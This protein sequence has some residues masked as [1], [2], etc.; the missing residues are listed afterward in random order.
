MDYGFSQFITDVEAGRQ[1]RTVSVTIAEFL[2]DIDGR[3]FSREALVRSLNGDAMPKLDDL[4]PLRFV[5]NAAASKDIRGSQLVGI[6]AS[7][8]AALPQFP[9][10]ML[11]LYGSLND[12]RA[13]TIRLRRFQPF[14]DVE[15]PETIPQF[16]SIFRTICERVPLL[17]E[18]LPVRVRFL[19][20]YTMQR[21][22]D[23]RP[24]QIARISCSSYTAIHQLMNQ[25]H[26]AGRVTHNNRFK[27][28][29]ARNYFRDVLIETG[30]TLGAWLEVRNWR[31]YNYEN[32]ASSYNDGVV[33]IDVDWTDV[34]VLEDAELFH[35][36]TLVMAWDIETYDANS[37]EAPQWQNRSSELSLA[38]CNFYWHW[39]TNMLFSV[40][41]SLRDVSA[42]EFEA[43][44]NTGAQRNPTVIVNCGSEQGLLRG[45][46]MLFRRFQPSFVMGFADTIYDWPWMFGRATQLPPV[47]VPG[48][49][50]VPF[51][52]Y[53]HS[54]LCYSECG[55]ILDGYGSDE[56]DIVERL[57]KHY[58]EPEEV[59][60]NAE[61]MIKS[62]QITTDGYVIIDMMIRNMK[63]APNAEVKHS[64][65]LAYF[66]ET[67]LG[68]K[69][70]I[71][72]DAESP[73]PGIRERRDHYAE[74]RRIIMEYNAGAPVGVPRSADGA[75]LGA[76]GQP[77]V[78]NSR[79][80]DYVYY[81]I[82]DAEACQKMAHK[83][84]LI[85]DNRAL[86]LE[87]RLSMNDVEWRAGGMKV[88]N[89]LIWN[90]R[91]RFA[92]AHGGTTMLYTHH[93]VAPELV[94]K[95]KGAYVAPPLYGLELYSPVFGLDVASL[96]PSIM[97]LYNL[98][99]SQ[100]IIFLHMVAGKLKP[101]YERMWRAVLE[102]GLEN[103]FEIR[104]TYAD[105][106]YVFFVPKHRGDRSKYG[107]LPLMIQ[108]IF[109][110]RI[111]KKEGAKKVKAFKL[112]VAEA[113][114]HSE[115][116]RERGE[117]IT[118]FEFVAKWRNECKKIKAESVRNRIIAWLDTWE[119]A[120]DLPAAAAY[121]L[122]YVAFV[123]KMET[124]NEKAMKLLM[125]TTYG[126]MGFDKHALFNLY[127]SSAV[128]AMGQHVIKTA[129]A[130]A[131]AYGFDLVYGDTDSMYLRR[132]LAFWGAQIDRLRE[133]E[134][135][136]RTEMDPDDP[137]AESKALVLL[138]EARREYYV[139][140]IPAA[141][142]DAKDVCAKV[143]KSFEV[144][145]DGL[146]TI[147]FA[148]EEVMVPGM[149]FQKKVYVGGVHED[150]AV[151]DPR[152]P[153]VH[154]L[155][156]FKDRVMLRGLDMVKQGFSKNTIDST[157]RMLDKLMDPLSDSNLLYVT[158]ARVVEAE[159]EHVLRNVDWTD[160][161]Q[162]V[163][164][165]T[166]KKHKK[167]IPVQE[168]V[169]RLVARGDPRTPADGEKFR[170]VVI[171]LDTASHNIY[172][173][174]VAL[175]AS[176][177]WELLEVARERG[178]PINQR[179]YLEN[180]LQ[181]TLCKFTSYMFDTPEHVHEGM[182]DKQRGEAIIK[183]A[184]KHISEILARLLNEGKEEY[185]QVKAYLHQVRNAKAPAIARVI[186]SMYSEVRSGHFYVYDDAPIVLATKPLAEV[187]RSAVFDGFAPF[188]SPIVP[189][190]SEDSPSLTPEVCV[191]ANEAYA[192]ITKTIEVARRSGVGAGDVKFE[193]DDLR[194]VD[195]FLDGLETQKARNLTQVQALARRSYALL[196]L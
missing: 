85:D 64:N 34:A 32:L 187:V 88:L 2:A 161:D 164:T 178:L 184:R 155:N 157:R 81:C 7:M 15:V 148:Y 151:L 68:I 150:A 43:R 106:D 163:Q 130:E 193:V 118:V 143:N 124:A 156:D 70:K 185:Y 95:I 39:S 45:F 110:R 86:C 114:R 6:N 76:N 37:S 4:E 113:I 159:I 79:M 30:L 125:N 153:D 128:T 71:D 49:A 122:D 42:A 26:R 14:I 134:E 69:N 19:E 131:R 142:K 136:V 112:D 99:H 55:R 12:G 183:A 83:L 111:V 61:R 141:I 177:S 179:Y 176:Q 139:D 96:Y 27:D 172:G 117:I 138:R 28:S 65:S 174:R 33:Y 189:T 62:Y 52:V 8:D 145:Y 101:D 119:A 194:A 60:I 87:T 109:D 190:L 84:G 165:R 94:E 100:A 158:P 9:E 54:L 123:E 20:A 129:Q 13:A 44:Y 180:Q 57:K 40:A 77:Y 115:E 24:R 186:A 102:I 104:F 31:R 146:K 181:N 59:K 63:N 73:D 82:V 74:L 108:S 147:T 137:E 188:E 48:G 98:C 196:G 140:V 92:A 170:Y 120:P 173:R 66:S 18:R 93:F 175:R 133:R 162:F 167:N 107:N 90:G 149:F 166:F 78:H 5:A 51:V 72:L 80:P 10:F 144:R 169:A 53:F 116:A 22:V 11:Y 56:K 127:L 3:K 135:Q 21:T 154:N 171:K 91:T 103:V 89:A 16:E 25:L 168:F 47:R 36:P 38:C 41:L 126:V 105:E 192:R 58:F 50:S 1:P 132:P 17:R 152:L 67:I 182:S 46:G 35:D 23:G 75:L 29:S 160:Y 97:I 195:A 191:A 121:D